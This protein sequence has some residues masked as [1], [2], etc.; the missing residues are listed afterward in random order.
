MLFQAGK[1]NT[2]EENIPV[3]ATT[4]WNFGAGRFI[5]D[6]ENASTIIRY[7]WMLI[8]STAL[9]TFFGLTMIYSASYGSQEMRFFKSQIFWIVIG[10]AGGTFSYYIGYKKLTEWSPLMVIGVLILLGIALF[11]KEVNGAHRWIFINLPGLSMS[12]QP[13]EFAKVVMALFVSGYCSKNFRTLPYLFNRNGLGKIFL[14]SGT[15]LGS[16]VAGGDLG[17]TVLVAAMIGCI[18]FAAGMPIRY[19]LLALVFVGIIA[20]YIY[21]FDAERLSRAITWLNPQEYKKKD[22]YQLWM[23]LMALG[24]GGWTGMGF[25]GSRF[26]AKY[27]PEQH[28]DFILSV[29]GEELGFLTVLFLVI[30]GYVLLVFSALKI[31]LNAK[32]RTSMLLGFGITSFIAFQAIINMI[33]IA[34]LGPTKGM[35]APFISYGGS[36]MVVCMT[37]IGILLSIAS[38]SINEDYNLPFLEKCKKISSKLFRRKK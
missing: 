1:N 21:F 14:I 16:I 11:S 33:V 29:V 2:G 20:A 15:V 3:S 34:G 24:S 8:L 35:P 36:N 31:S 13:S 27:L 9:L 23:S 28:T 17:T 4:S 12:I 7:A 32:N 5:S 30:G 38:S 22:G 26:K 37:S 19:V 10:I 18:L 25:L 6:E